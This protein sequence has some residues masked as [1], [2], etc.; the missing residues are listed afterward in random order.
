M[1]NKTVTITSNAVNAPKKTVRIK[2]Q[3]KPKPSG[4]A[5]TTTGGP[6]VN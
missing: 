2:G 1:I 4:G 3:V 5:P 6:T